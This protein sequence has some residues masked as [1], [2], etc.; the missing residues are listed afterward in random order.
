MLRFSLIIPAHNERELLPRLLDTVDL[1]RARFAEGE[2]A[3]EV[4]VADNASTDGTGDLAAE[5]GC[6]VVRVTER[7]IAA[8]RN[9]GARVARGEVLCFVDADMRIDVESFNAIDQAIRRPDIIAGATG[10]RL[11]RWSL[12]IALT[13]ALIVPLVIL[14]R[15]DTG[16]VFCRRADF[17][18]VGGYDE[19]R[20]IGEDVAFLWAMRLL[21]KKRGQRLVRLRK[22]KATTSMRKFDQHGDWH[23][24][25]QV[26]PYG[27]PALFRPGSKSPIAKRYW[28]GDDR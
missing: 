6:V 18:A 20:E 27:F 24:L 26:I 21:G 12:G 28:Y 19:R 4:I 2:D 10:V 5:R 23:Y 9:G 22:F 15:I 16:V 13:Y 25:T 3:V 1:A 8:A 17:E 11:E 7:L 14:M